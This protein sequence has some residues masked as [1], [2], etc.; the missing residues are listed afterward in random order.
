MSRKIMIYGAGHMGLAIVL[1]LIRKGH[2]DVQIVD[3]SESR[4]RLLSE[5]FQLSVLPKSAALGSGD[6]VVLAMPPQAFAEFA[7]S[8]AVPRHHAGPVVSV[9]AGVTMSTIAKSLG[10]TQ[11]IRSIPNTPSEVFQGMT[12]FCAS[13]ETT[14]ENIEWT[15]RL[16]EAFGKAVWVA[17]EALIDPATA[18]C[19]GGPAFVAYIA[20]AMQAFATSV[21]FDAP[22]AVL[23]T[24]Q[25][26]RGTAELI[27]T[28]GKPAMQI[29]R[30]VMTPQGTTERGIKH[31][32]EHKLHDILQAA[33][34][35]S[36]ERSRELGRTT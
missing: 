12:V 8:G 29:C 30:E 27:E 19:G 23:M 21:G 22:S 32:D 26:L 10:V 2:T 4:R 18:L 13:P 11:V 31:F 35:R 25:V 33:L 17:D 6:L 16:F 15:R 1:G 28:T 36:T 34:S 3:P 7:S 5:Q 14:A 20:D 24:T 9:M